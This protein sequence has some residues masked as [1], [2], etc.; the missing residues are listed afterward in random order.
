MWENFDFTLLFQGVSVAIIGALSGW[1]TNRASVK[2]E[3]RNTDANNRAKME[4]EAYQRAREMDTET[5][6]RKDAELAELRAERAQLKEEINL[7][8]ERVAA[9]ELEH[10][11]CDTKGDGYYDD[12][13]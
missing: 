4:D 2:S 6:A 11:N 5:I 1:L 3:I 7:L 10:H 9:L 13:V 12:K 8:K